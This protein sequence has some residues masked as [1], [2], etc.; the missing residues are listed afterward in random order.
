MNSKGKFK[1]LENTIHQLFDA[2][3]KVMRYEIPLYQRK[4]TWN[5]EQI[6]PLLEDI[7]ARSKDKSQHYMGIMAT[8][9]SE[10]TNQ[11]ASHTNTYIR[12]IDGQQR[13]TTSILIIDVLKKMIAER[14]NYGYVGGF[15]YDYKGVTFRNEIKTSVS[16]DI[17]NIAKW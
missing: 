2:G 15:S 11:D 7:V 8:T 10:V 5:A 16:T 9:K 3:D 1:L 12:V 13:I 17:S 6:E 4:Y 14:D